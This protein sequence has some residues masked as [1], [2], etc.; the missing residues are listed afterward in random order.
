MHQQLKPHSA[1]SWLQREG[2][3]ISLV[4]D[5]L[6][7]LPKV[8]GLVVLQHTL[9]QAALHFLGPSGGT[10]SRVSLGVKPAVQQ[11]RSGALALVLVLVPVHMLVHLGMDSMHHKTGWTSETQKPRSCT[12]QKHGVI[13]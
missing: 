12:V 7:Q 13:C 1:C 3:C 9:I 2:G 11:V 10:P 4:A 8:T 6:P 5:L